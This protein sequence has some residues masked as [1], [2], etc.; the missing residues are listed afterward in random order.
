MSMNIDEAALEEALK[1]DQQLKNPKPYAAPQVKSVAAEGSL[2]A[3][4]DMGFGPKAPAAAEPGPTITN[5]SAV[6]K[7]DP[8]AKALM[9]RMLAELQRAQAQAESF[10]A[11]SFEMEAQQLE[12]SKVER[13]EN[14]R[15][16][17]AAA[18]FTR[19]AA[20]MGDVEGYKKLALAAFSAAD[21]FIKVRALPPTE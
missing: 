20:E 7:L 17:V 9:E 4:V 3:S 8:E 1:H 5:I 12:Q 18:I 19:H 16:N 13:A 14:L 10:A 6:S 15:T 21:T 2:D 11:H